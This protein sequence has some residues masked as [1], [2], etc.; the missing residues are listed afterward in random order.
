MKPHHAHWPQRVP[1]SFTPTH[2]TLCDNLAISAKR[3]PDKAAL[4]F[5]GRRLSYRELLQQS[6]S[7]AAWLA[8][9]GVKQGDRVLLYMQNC[10]QWV[11]AHFGILRANAVVVPVN[12]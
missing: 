7:I 1:H 2:T 11:V 5:L 9:N 6:E 4:V 3:F 8:A 10:P 12:P